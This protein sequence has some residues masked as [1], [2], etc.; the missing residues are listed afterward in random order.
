M[1]KLKIERALY[2]WKRVRDL[3]TLAEQV[4]KTNGLQPWH[5][6]LWL[7]SDFDADKWNGMIDDL[8]GWFKYLKM[9]GSWE[10]GKQKEIQ[11]VCPTIR[12]SSR[13]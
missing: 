4:V 2:P 11:L 7:A 10:T 8:N 6:K 13:L 12:P 3:G 5:V 9:N 1:V